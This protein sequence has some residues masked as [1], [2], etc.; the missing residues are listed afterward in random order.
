ML[1]RY[2]KVLRIE[3]GK[4]GLERLYFRGYTFLTKSI[5]AS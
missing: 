3:K 2:A 4:V 5:W 1:K